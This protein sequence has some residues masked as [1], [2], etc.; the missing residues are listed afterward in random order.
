MPDLFLGRYVSLGFLGKGSM[1]QVWLAHPVGQPDRH[2]VV[3]VMHPSVANQPRFRQFFEREI[4]SMSNLRHPYIVQLLDSSCLDQRGPIL[5]LEYVPGAT[6]EAVLEKQ[7][8]LPV[9]H[10]GLLLGYLCHALEA[11]HGIGV[12]HRDL[13]PA[14]LMIVGPGTLEESLRVMDFGLAQFADKPHFTAERLAGSEQTMAS[15]T[16][17][18]ISPESLRGDEVDARTDLYSVGVIL[19]EMLTGHAPFPHSDVK[20]IL[21]AHLHD[22][23]LSFALVGA[24]D[25]PRAVEAIVQQC[26]SKYPVERP[27]SARD[28]AQ[29]FSEAIGVDVW[30]AARPEG[31]PDRPVVAN[32][33]KPAPVAERNAIVHQMD[34]WMPEPIAVVKLR[35]FLEDM[36]G[37]VVASEPGLLKIR[38]GEPVQTRSGRVILA[39]LKDQH[40]VEIEMRM[41]KTD[42]RDNRLS[43][44]VL[45]RPFSDPILMQLPDWRN[46]CQ[47][48]YT[49]LQSYLMV[50]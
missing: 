18:Y 1:G 30:E 17:S 7:K 37:K 8:R 14:N 12:V 47:K 6:L 16:P 10:V 33:S 27:R 26:L 23:P 28:V 9:G 25:V 2:V 50:R 3:K 35:G 20:R 24:R 22:Q 29:Q 44:T 21:N 19:F 40:P 5:V 39:K 45:F 41:A 11:A 4:Q 15:G 32:A 31:V 46:R 38:L 49:E 34:A 42:H 48:L 13:K 43:V 36:G